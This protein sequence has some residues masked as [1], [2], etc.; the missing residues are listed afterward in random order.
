[1]LPLL[2]SRFSTALTTCAFRFSLNLL[3]CSSASSWSTGLGS[4]VGCVDGVEGLEEVDVFALAGSTAGEGGTLLVTPLLLMKGCR[5]SVRAYGLS[6]GSLVKHLETKSLAESDSSAGIG[7]GSLE[8]V[9]WNR[10]AMWLLNSLNGG[11][12]VAICSTVQPTLQMSDF[13]EYRCSM[14]TS[15]DMNTGVPLNERFAAES[16]LCRYLEAPKSANLQTPRLSTRM[17]CPLMSR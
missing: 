10:A 15:G 3:N 5:R 12:P 17:F 14:I 13:F 11:F 7:G 16:A 6:L 2:L 4:L 1:M 9:M 8:A